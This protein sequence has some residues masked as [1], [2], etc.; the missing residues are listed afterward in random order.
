MRVAKLILIALVV[1]TL[2]AVIHYSLPR[3]EVVRVVGVDTRLES[4]GWNRFFFAAA[5]SG[6]AASD[7]RDVRYVEA[8]RPNGRERVFRNEDTGWGWPPYFKLNA[9]DM[10]ARA[11]DLVSTGAEPRWI[12]VSYYGI[13]SQ[14]FSIYP[15]I[16]RVREVEGPEVMIVPWTR[17]IA[18]VLLGSLALWL[19]VR[20]RRLRQQ[21]IEPF[22]DRVVERK[23]AARGRIARAFDRLLGRG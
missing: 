8:V 6:M 5:P 2:G 9:A 20:L 18:F 21:R 13:R 15:N 22:V 19:Y 17:I 14:V 10:Q 11:R 12:A 3:H 1:V 23:R 7:T 4:F 16:L